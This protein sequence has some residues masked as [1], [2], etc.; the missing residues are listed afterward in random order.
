MKNWKRYTFI[1]FIAIL[2]IVFLFM[3]FIFNDSNNL[4]GTW[5]Y[6]YIDQFNT[7]VR[8]STYYAFSGNK[9]TYRT[10][11]DTKFLPFINR[12]EHGTFSIETDEEGNTYIIFFINVGRSYRRLF[13]HNGNKIIMGS[14]EF[15][16]IY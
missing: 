5:E 15:Y 14:R 3:Q 1:G 9:Y 16:R 4:N 6:M 7:R 12:I 8:G 13:S 11:V 10:F 2:I